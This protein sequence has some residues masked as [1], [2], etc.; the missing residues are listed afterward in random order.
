MSDCNH[1]KPH[2]DCKISG[3]RKHAVPSI[4]G[5]VM[6]TAATISYAG[7][8]QARDLCFL[9]GVA[10]VLSTGTLRFK[11]GDVVTEPYG[12]LTVPLRT[13]GGIVLYPFMSC[14]RAC[15][16]LSAQMYW[17]LNSGMS[18]TS[19]MNWYGPLVGFTDCTME[20]T[21]W[22]RHGFNELPASTRFTRTHLYQMHRHFRHPR[23]AKM[24]NA[25]EKDESRRHVR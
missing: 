23:A 3:K 15:L 13:P 6:D 7:Y 12:I 10:C 25:F 5:G 14:R 9:T 16:F 4:L 21:Y 19:L 22:S 18:G 24:Y 1:A 2:L 20:R 17:M 11:F 8:P